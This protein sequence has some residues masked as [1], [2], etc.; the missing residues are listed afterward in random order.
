M[1]MKLLETRIKPLSFVP[2]LGKP[3]K[4]YS[5][6]FAARLFPV[7][8][9]GIVFT[10]V[11]I[12]F[13]ITI[14]DGTTEFESDFIRIFGITLI[15]FVLAIYLVI[16]NAYRYIA[17][18]ENG[19]VLKKRFSIFEIRY[20]DI[21][22]VELRSWG[23]AIDIFLRDGTFVSMGESERLLGYFPYPR[24]FKGVRIVKIKDLYEDLNK[25]VT[26]QAHNNGYDQ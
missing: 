11:L 19:I 8:L 21:E 16:G 6:T 22:K 2:I 3:E 23:D 5:T 15:L 13:I 20:R 26:A 4:I 10:I 24:L 17:L 25:K 7:F 14:I 9:F 18:F 1:Q 12:P